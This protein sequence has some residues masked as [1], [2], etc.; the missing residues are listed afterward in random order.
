MQSLCALYATFSLE[1]H[2]K[3]RLNLFNS[4]IFWHKVCRR[5][6]V[7]KIVVPMMRHKGS[8]STSLQLLT[9]PQRIFSAIIRDVQR[10][11]RAIDLEFYIFEED[12]IGRAFI[13]LLCR[14]ARQGVAVR[15]LLDG[16]GSRNVR[17]KTINRLTASGVEIRTTPLMANS[18]NHR[19]IVVV[20]DSVAYTGGINIADRY[21]A[22]NNLGV[23][24]DVALRIEGDIARQM[25]RILDYDTLLLE[26]VS[27][28]L[29][30]REDALIR[31]YASE[32]QG[33][34]AM[35]LLLDDVAIGATSSITI[36]TPYLFPSHDMLQRLASAVVR[37]VAVSIIVPA[38]CDVAMLDSLMPL[39]VDKAVDAG[40]E[41]RQAAC[42][43][44]HAKMAIVD[45]RRVVVGSAN[46]DAR[47]L[48]VNRELMV[49]TTDAGVCRAALHFIERLN[50]LPYPR[51]ETKRANLI[52]RLFAHIL[53]PML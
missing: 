8:C 18:R 21:V 48:R 4:Q 51:P 1:S 52:S 22:G 41:I 2:Y 20:D 32:M 44:L 11:R 9:T 29:M 47:S 46:L 37:G 7:N 50:S 6:C 34:R 14:K 38:R 39:F 16:F 12:N 5:A 36:T 27:S 35:E 42:G 13:E 24:H 26:G 10:A 31:L 43:F 23:W 15:M 3:D 40:I 45:D 30:V 25:R 53:S 19:K 49:S 33:A 17:R 28:E